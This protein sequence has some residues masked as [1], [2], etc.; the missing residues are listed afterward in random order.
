MQELLEQDKRLF[1]M[2]AEGLDVL[3]SCF[4]LEVETLEKDA[5]QY[6]DVDVVLA[7][8]GGLAIDA[9]KWLAEHLGKKAE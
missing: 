4:G 5:P 7:M 9:G 6:A 3:N 8:G 2:P 1:W